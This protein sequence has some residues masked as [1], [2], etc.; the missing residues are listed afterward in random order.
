MQKKNMKTIICGF[1]ILVGV[2]AVIL[3]FV[4]FGKDTG[5]TESSKTYGGD[6][7]TGIQNASSQAANNT[8]YLAGIAKF[9]G[10]SILLVSG[11]LSIA[12]FG[13]KFVDDN[14]RIKAVEANVSIPTTTLNKE[15]IIEH[16]L[17]D[18]D[19]EGMPNVPRSTR[20]NTEPVEDN[21][22]PGTLNS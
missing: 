18:K 10:G 15:S 2:L 5:Y 7:Y 8:Y 22:A 19:E 20:E 1:G 21:T 12:Y 14:D 11:L 9:A 3:A 13:I 16:K 4:C 17:T 6:A